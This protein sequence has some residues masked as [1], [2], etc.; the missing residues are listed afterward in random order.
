[1]PILL[2]TL[3]FLTF[4]QDSM[5]TVGERNGFKGFKKQFSGRFKRLVSNK[6]KDT[7]SPIPAELKPQLKTIYVY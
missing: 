3:T 4:I 1:M 2:N 7:T 6:T 5:I